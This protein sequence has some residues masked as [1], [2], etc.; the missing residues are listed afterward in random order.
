MAS[1]QL[2]NLSASGLNMRSIHNRIN[3]LEAKSECFKEVVFP[4]LAQ[5]ACGLA[6]GLCVT[7]AQSDGERGEGS[8]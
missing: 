4:E 5:L 2:L 8:R 3:S 7:K 6:P 1:P